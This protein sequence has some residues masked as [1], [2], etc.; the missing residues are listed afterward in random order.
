MERPGI[1]KLAGRT[2]DLTLTRNPI[3]VY[4]GYSIITS[5]ENNGLTLTS[6]L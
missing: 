6:S 3:L 1:A 5:T 4:E 2:A